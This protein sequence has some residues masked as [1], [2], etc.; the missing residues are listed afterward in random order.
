MIDIKSEKKRKK[1]MR[2]NQATKGKYRK[3]TKVNKHELET[4]IFGEY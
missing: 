2:E 1:K 3:K 4:E